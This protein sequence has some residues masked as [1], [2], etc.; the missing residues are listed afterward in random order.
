MDRIPAVWTRIE[1]LQSL[2]AKPDFEPLA[3][4]FKRVV[5]IIKQAEQKGLYDSRDAVDNSLFEHPSEEG[6]YQAYQKIEQKVAAKLIKG[7]MEG[8]LLAVASLRKTVDEFFDEVLVMSEDVKLRQNR[9]AL[10]GG[11]AALFEKFADFSKI[12]T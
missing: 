4:A 2:K 7:E 12:S 8:A 5:N 6:L 11:I 3:V 1:V 10:L 9:L